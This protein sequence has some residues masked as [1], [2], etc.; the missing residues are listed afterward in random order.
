MAPHGA[1][2]DPDAPVPGRER[3]HPAV[4]FVTWL[5]TVAIG[6]S[7]VAIV[8]SLTFWV[9]RRLLGW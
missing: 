2:P 4:E 8:V 6:L 1:A 7:M 5:L 3:R 9:V